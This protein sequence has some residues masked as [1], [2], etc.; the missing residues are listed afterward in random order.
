M[1]KSALDLVSSCENF[2]EYIVG[3]L[4]LLEIDHEP[5]VPLLGNRCLDL[6]LHRVLSFCLRVMRFQYTTYQ[7]LAR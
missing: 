5:L 6:L 4:I 7:L 2:L 1:H 3:K